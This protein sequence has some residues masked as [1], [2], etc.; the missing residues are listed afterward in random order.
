M[1]NPSSGKPLETGFGEAPPEADHAALSDD[2]L[3]AQCRVDTFRAGGKGGQHQNK[4]ESG[5]RLTHEPTGIVATAR[6]S[7][8]QS[9]NRETAL[10]RLRERLEAQAHEP[11]PR[12]PTRVPLKEKRK[13]VD[14][15]K[16]KSRVKRLRRK[17]DIVDD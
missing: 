3:L 1:S 17:P 9:R 2:E 14:E 11:T 13:R 5:V 6:D 7:R 8:S 10:A 15:K 12:V 16:R 4:A